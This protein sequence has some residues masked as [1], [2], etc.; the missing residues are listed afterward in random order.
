[1]GQEAPMPVLGA[2]FLGEPCPSSRR[3]LHLYC[4]RSHC[5]QRLA[6]SGPCLAF[7][8]RITQVAPTLCS[9]LLWRQLQRGPAFWRQNSPIGCFVDTARYRARQWPP[10]LQPPSPSGELAKS[11]SLL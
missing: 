3:R 2:S 6:A 5:K 10:L 9:S 7:H 11:A 4:L 8:P 1:M